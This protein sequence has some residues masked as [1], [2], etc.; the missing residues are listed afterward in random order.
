MGP[1]THELAAAPEADVRAISV[2]IVSLMPRSS[3]P[4]ADQE[5]AAERSHPQGAVLFAGACATC[6][7][8]GASMMN[9][10][11]PD[12]TLGTPLH[13]ANPRDTIQIILQGLRSPTGRS[14]PTMPAYAGAFTDAQIGEIA[15]YLRAR[16]TR[17]APW[18]GDLAREAG[19]AR[20]EGLS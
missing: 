18:S 16:Y 17:D 2:Y 10:G 19:A 4:T 8:P 6:H 11:R 13:E 1:V 7:S 9:E 14:G 12:L 20:R 5:Q 3:E 15:A